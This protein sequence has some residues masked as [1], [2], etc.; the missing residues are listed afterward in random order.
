MTK[1]NILSGTSLEVKAYW[2]AKYSENSIDWDIGSVSSPFKEYIDQIDNKSQKIL[3]PGAG[4]AY[5]AEYLFVNG[6]KSVYVLDISSNAINGFKQ[7]F[8]DFPDKQLLNQDFFNHIDTYDLILEQTFFCAINPPDRKKYVK[9]VH[10]LLNDKGRLVGLLF[11]HEFE[12]AGP[13]FGG[14]VKEYKELFSPYFEFKTF[15]VAYNSIKPRHNREH[16][17]NFLKNK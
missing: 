17:I 1:N 9:K 11:N 3:I 10:S 13:P 6:F 14:S 16:F 15:E 5:E 2:D 12:K 4:N 7:R 8:P